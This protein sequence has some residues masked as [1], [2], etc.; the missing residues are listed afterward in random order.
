MDVRFERSEED[1]Q[2]LNKLKGDINV[3]IKQVKEEFED[4]SKPGGIK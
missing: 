2:R 3:F 1:K 4:A